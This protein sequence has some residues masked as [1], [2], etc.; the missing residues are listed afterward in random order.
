MREVANEVKRLVSVVIPVYNEAENVSDAYN[1]VRAVF[2]D[3]LRDYDFEIVFTDN[4]STDNTYA[5]I[6]QLAKNDPRV[7]VASFVRNYGFNRSLLTGYRLAEGEVAIQLDC[8]LQDPPEL[9]PEFLRHWEAGSDVVVAV[10]KKRVEAGWLTFL[11]KTFYR[12]LRRISQDNLV[13]DGGDY[14]L[15]DR[16]ILDKLKSI[17]DSAPYVRGLV[18][19]LAR[20]QSTF[21]YERKERLRGESKFPVMRLVTLAID[22]VVSHSTIPLRLASI[23][24]FL[25]A[26]FAVLLALMYVFLRLFLGV[27]MPAGFTTSVILEL[28]SIGLNAIF[29]GIIGEYLGRIHMQLR[30]TPLTVIQKGINLT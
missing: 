9:F 7:R 21:P 12:G 23:F 19:S 28:L 26:I 11:R 24:G 5:E 30:Q 3:E 10:R 22:G 8:D 14:R 13:V 27:E 29:L 25:V 17:H 4:H 15:V 2:E 1:R 18:S 6:A 20:N 16:S